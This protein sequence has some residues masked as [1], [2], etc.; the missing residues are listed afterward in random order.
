M[1][2]SQDLG[3]VRQAQDIIHTIRDQHA[4]NK[5]KQKWNKIDILYF[6]TLSLYLLCNYPSIK[7]VSYL[8]SVNE[9]QLLGSV[10]IVW[11][12]DKIS[13]WYH[14]CCGF[15]QLFKGT[16]SGVHSINVTNIF[17]ER[18]FSVHLEDKTNNVS[19]AHYTT[20]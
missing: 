10:W 9:K 15:I 6:I 12:I 11:Q 4:S 8:S 5:P 1:P 14:R 20:L 3:S 19:K 16:C 2:T 7:K 17:I 18:K 13:G